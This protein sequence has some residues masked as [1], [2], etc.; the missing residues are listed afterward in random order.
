MFMSCNFACYA[1]SNDE[2]NRIRMKVIVVSLQAPSQKFS[3]GAK[4][5]HEYTPSDLHVEVFS[6]FGGLFIR[7]FYLYTE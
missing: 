3:E 1:T 2:E 4:T 6:T 5:N 7:H